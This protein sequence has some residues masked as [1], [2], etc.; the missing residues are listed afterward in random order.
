MSKRKTR[1]AGADTGKSNERVKKH[2]AGPKGNEL[3]I[4]DQTFAGAVK[5]LTN[6]TKLGEMQDASPSTQ[7]KDEQRQRRLRDTLSE[8]FGVMPTIG[9]PQFADDASPRQMQH[10]PGARV[11]HVEP[12]PE[13]ASAQPDPCT[14]NPGV[15]DRFDGHEGKCN[16]NLVEHEDITFLKPYDDIDHNVLAPILNALDKQFPARFEVKRVVFKLEELEYIKLPEAYEEYYPTND[17]AGSAPTKT[18][19]LRKLDAKIRNRKGVWK[20]WREKDKRD[21]QPRVVQNMQIMGGTNQ[22][23]AVNDGDMTQVHFSFGYGEAE[24]KAAKQM[25]TRGGSPSLGLKV[26][27]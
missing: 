6:L 10:E 8:L 9:P 2:R 15:C 16:A 20:S 22:F 3:R 26:I 17:V 24:F 1:A 23:A 7:A 4:R 13:S 11:S 14:K 21:K 18:P 19:L 5:Y 12:R 25:F 27:L